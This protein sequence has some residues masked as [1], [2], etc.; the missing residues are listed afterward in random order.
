MP[1]KPF[2]ATLTR[3]LNL[4]ALAMP[5]NGVCNAL[6]LGIKPHSSVYGLANAA[7]SAPEV[8]IAGLTN[9]GSIDDSGWVIV[10][11][12]DSSHSGKEGRIAAGST[13]TQ[14]QIEAETSGVIQRFTREDA[15][16]L[17]NDYKSTWARLKRAVVGLPVFKGHPDAVRF[18]KQFPD[19]TPSGT[20]ADMEVRDEGLALR[21]VLTEQG[22]ADVDAGWKF[23][24]PYW[25]GRHV[26]DEGGRKIIAPFKLLSLGLVPRGNIPDLSLVNSEDPDSTDTTMNKHLLKVLI[27]LG[28]ITE[29]T[30]TDTALANSATEALPGAV[31][32]LQADKAAA[33]Q[34]VTTLTAQ[35]TALEGEKVAL[36]NSAE[37]LTTRATSAETTLKNFRAAA[38]KHRVGLALKAGKISA[39]EA[40][41]QETALA[42][43]ADFDV[44]AGKL[45]ALPSKLRTESQLGNLG[46]SGKEQQGRTQQVVGLVNAHMD[47]HAC[48]YDTAFA[49]VKADPKHAAIFSAMKKP[50]AKS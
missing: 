48:D 49:A 18:A 42:N 14:E 19:K 16:G 12:G 43:A 47:A 27:A 22:A 10:P 39:A 2:A 17:V 11:Y 6:Q 45:E 32:K 1:L 20:I 5:C 7:D 24:S 4:S 25:L 46:A 31:E 9:A 44:E 8:G 34:A 50:E 38:A 26:G 35:K 29:A 23:V 3:V 41:A 15:I 13:R 33:E 21:P 30:A 28:L 37:Q 40:A 36:A